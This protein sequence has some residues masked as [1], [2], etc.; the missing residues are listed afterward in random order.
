MNLTFTND[1][2]AEYLHWQK[3]D[4]Q[5]L[6][7]INQLLKDVKGDPFEGVGKPEPLKYEFA[8]CWLRRITDEHKLAYEVTD[9][10][11]VIISRRYQLL[12]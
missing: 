2:V 4:R 5:I 12:I 11:I 3:A 9:S 10:D 1:S 8:G 7:K 6:K